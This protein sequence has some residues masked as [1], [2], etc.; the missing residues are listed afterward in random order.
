VFLHV[1]GDFLGSIGVCASAIIYYFTDWPA[2]RYIDPAFSVIIVLMLIHGSWQ[3]FKKTSKIVLERC[4]DSVD[5]DVVMEALTHIS[6]V[7]AVHE[8]HIWE[9]SKWT[10]IA[11][12]HLVVEEREMNGRVLGMVHNLMISYGIYSSTVQIE[13]AEDFPAGIDN[14]SSCFYATA[15][16]KKKRAFLTPPVYQHAIG[17]P[18]LHIPGQEDEH[19]HHDHDHD[20]DHHD[21]GHK[22]KH[23]EKGHSHKE[24]TVS[25]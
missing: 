10:Y 13:F 18:H 3:L 9:L 20:H 22:H 23:E 21:H 1:F 7:A 12:I 11:V 6:G 4:P 15:L 5:R 25:V 24:E 17:C 2:K 8:L 14:T 19:D 16:E